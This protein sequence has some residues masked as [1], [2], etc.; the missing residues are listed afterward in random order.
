M[1]GVACCCEH[2]NEAARF[3]KGGIIFDELSELGSG[4][5]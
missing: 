1:S 5:R 4:K 2:G 3:I